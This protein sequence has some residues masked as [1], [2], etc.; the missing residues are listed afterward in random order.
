MKHAISKFS[1]FELVCLLAY[2]WMDLTCKRNIALKIVHYLSFMFR[3]HNRMVIRC[4]SLLPLCSEFGFLQHTFI[5]PKSN[6][7]P[8]S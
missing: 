7:Y 8:D 4:N 6:G 1:F 5:P 3:L 2:A